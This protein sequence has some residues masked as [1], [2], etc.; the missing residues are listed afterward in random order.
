MIRFLGWGRSIV[1]SVVNGI[2]RAVV[3][4]ILLL[5]VLLIFSLARGDG[6]PGNM[7][8]ALDLREPIAD[9]SASPATVFTPRR[10]T[11]MEVVLGLETAGR[12]KRVKGMVMKL[13]NG[14]LSTAEGQEI[15]AAIERFRSRDKFVIAQTT[16][17]FGAGLGDY[18]AASAANE[19]WMQ[20]KAPFTPSGAG[21]GGL[22]LRG[23]LDKIE[24]EPQ[25]VKRAEY[26]SAAD[27]FMEKQM[28]AADR[29]QLTRLMQSVYDSAV[30]R[31]A[32]NRKLSREDVVA[33]LEASPQ[34]SEDVLKRRLI[35][36]I[37]YDDQATAAANA[38][39]G[40]GV[41]T[42]KF[43]NYARD[44]AK[45]LGDG[46][47]AIVEAAGEIRDGTAKNSLL[48]A[49]A[50]IASDDLSEA[51]RQA[52]R[53]KSIK[54]IVLRVDS[55]GGSVTA[56]DQIL[57][58][59]KGAQAAGKPVV[60][61]MGGV[62]ASGGYFISTT[63]NR[64]VAQ[65]GTITGSIGVLT[66]KISFNKTLG[67]VGANSEQ[68]SV[69]RNTLMGS[70]LSPYTPEQLAI[71]N[72]QADVIY[73]D[74]TAKVAAGRKLPIAKVREVARGRV[75]SGTDAQT[76]GLVDRLG[77]FW[78]AAGEAAVLAK[79]PPAEMVFKI[80]P[81]R[82]GL[83]GSLSRLMGDMDASFGLLGRIE[84]LLNLP[85]LQ[86]LLGGI[87]ELPAGELSGGVSLKAPGLP[88][89]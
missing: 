66:G 63:A 43:M 44:A 65:P 83:L 84:S 23:V 72:R 40:S 89:P 34:F 85:A 49:S 38:R 45:P 12:D 19:I 53:D 14:A 8:L 51:I 5:A 36:R 57:H 52:T 6:Q 54:A 81:R 76:H 29:E 78:T 25:I 46:N 60:V 41:K 42:V 31:V 24:A 86:A 68:V 3:A 74:F 17:F 13:G 26:K 75:W 58:A 77:G 4:L 79:V 47:I 21:G 70:P 35:D 67:L 7:V 28:S 27:M 88:E 48:G 18:V 32:T 82:T 64:I 33:G 1:M 59:V 11:V 22:F 62:V 2:A 87:S 10:V 50:G 37:G 39:A 15:A 20:P 71:L 80:Y 16:A 30:A 55:P 61:S 73:D 9:S 56:S 69:G